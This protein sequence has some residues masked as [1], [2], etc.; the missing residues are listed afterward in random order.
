[1][2][3]LEIK[4]TE[5]CM[6]VYTKPECRLKISNLGDFPM[7]KGQRKMAQIPSSSSMREVYDGEKTGGK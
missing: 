2:Q 4:V 6:Y 3:K 1:M 5:T 7:R